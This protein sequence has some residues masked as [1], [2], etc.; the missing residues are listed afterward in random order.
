[1]DNFKFEIKGERLFIV[2]GGKIN[3][4]N[5][6]IFEKEFW[7]EIKGKE[8]SSVEIDAKNLEYLSSAGLRS[9]F[10]IKDEI[11]DFKII[12]VSDEIYSIFDVTGF[13]NMMDIEKTK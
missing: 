9:I 11:D 5:A 2:V 4:Y 10:C 6:G 13:T 3:T 7:A 1:M 8:V 12:N